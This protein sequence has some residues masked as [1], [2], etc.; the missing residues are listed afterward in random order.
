MLTLQLHVNSPA[1]FLFP[2]LSSAG[3][4]RYD[5]ITEPYTLLRKGFIFLGTS[6]KTA[7][8]S[9]LTPRAAQDLVNLKILKKK[10]KTRLSS[11]SATLYAFEEVVGI[12]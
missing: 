8:A 7:E 4:V 10:K 9:N 12:S 2:L 1:V 3:N 11:Q 5:S 6:F